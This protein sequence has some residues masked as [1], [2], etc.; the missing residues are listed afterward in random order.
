MTSARPP[1][2]VAVVLVAG[3]GNRLRPL[4]NDCPKALVCVAGET[5]LSRT[6]RMLVDHGVGELVLA[7]GFCEGAVRSAMA[8]CPI[9]VHFCHNP[10]F[11]TTQNSVSLLA[12][13]EAVGGRPFYKLDGDLLFDSRVLDRLDAA[14]DDFCVA[15]DSSAVLGPEE[16]KVLV[17][18]NSDRITAFG[19]AL[20]PKTAFGESIGVERLQGHVVQ[21]VFAQL[22]CAHDAGETQLYY[23][24]LYARML[25]GGARAK[26]VHVSDLAWAEIDTLQDLRTAEELCNAARLG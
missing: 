25:A 19:K 20:D 21:E 11:S 2:S 3:V 17:E 18:K 9:P 15:V 14:M 6:V 1:A 26:A 7:T 24:D 13:A 8:S 23:E 4:T 22:R 16:M 5:I 10:L 12:C